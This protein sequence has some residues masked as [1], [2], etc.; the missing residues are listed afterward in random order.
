MRSE[1]TF[2]DTGGKIVKRLKSTARSHETMLKRATIEVV[3]CFLYEV[4]MKRVE[5]TIHGNVGPSNDYTISSTRSLQEFMRV[6]NG[7]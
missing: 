5:D 1:R 4:F 3:L 7:V 2:F 6:E